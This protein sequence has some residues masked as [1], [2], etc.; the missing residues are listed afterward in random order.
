MS[1]IPPPTLGESAGQVSSDGRWVWTGS[2]WESALS[3]D[4]H[5]RWDG[6]QWVP[7]DSS[8]QTS[9]PPVA[10]DESG[11]TPTAAELDDPHQYAADPLPPKVKE[12]PAESLYHAVGLAVG[13]GWIARRP[14][15]SWHLMAI[16]QLKSVALVPPTNFVEWINSRNVVAPLPDLAIRDEGGHSMRIS[17]GKLTQDGCASLTRQLPSTVEVTIAARE[18]LQ[19]GSLPGNWGH[20]FKNAWRVWPYH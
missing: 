1:E 12:L 7:A 16:P 18:F 2:S 11:P 19:T 10:V 6:T 17:V 5:W 9:R 4:G 13:D 15:A 8:A 14:L 3:P 20:R